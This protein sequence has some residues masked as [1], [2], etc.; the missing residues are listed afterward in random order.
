M[1]T[2]PEQLDADVPLRLAIC[3]AGEI[4]GGV[5]RCVLTL[6]VG[7][8]GAGHR[9]LALVF[10]EG[11]LASRLR[12]EGVETLVVGSG[13]KYD[14]RQIGLI[15]QA[16]RAY[17]INILHVHGYRAT[18]VAGLASRGLPVR[19]MRTEHGRLEPLAAWRDLVGHV[20]IAG[21]ELA[22]RLVAR[23]TVDAGVS[24]SAEI[25]GAAGARSIRRPSRVILNGMDPTGMDAEPAGKRHSGFHIGIVGRIVKVKGHDHLLDAMRRLQHLPDV[26]L[27]VFG[28][29]PLRARCERRAH[30]L[31]LSG[32]VT[33][34]GFC[35]D[36]PARMRSLDVLAMP[37]EH[38]GV[39]Y[40]LLEAMY[41][42]VPVV[43]TA[44]G[45]L[46]EVL[47]HGRSGL[48]VPPRNSGALAVSL[49][50]LY[51]DAGLRRRLGDGGRARVEEAFLASRMVDEYIAAYREIAAQ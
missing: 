3:C 14:P 29:G 33:F 5:E 41:L 27:H 16:L 46:P 21:N 45:G 49:E 8:I 38:E 10:H 7:L 44:V 22:E 31:G 12:A 25:A 43:A 48:L 11:A 26:H 23:A 20:R 30:R 28:S 15:R 1:R 4:W 47:E 37:S 42:R 39:P 51:R 34:H 36:M 24:V 9:P 13:G 6:A 40:T 50:G 32:R 18:I 17:R 35:A 19:V 2:L